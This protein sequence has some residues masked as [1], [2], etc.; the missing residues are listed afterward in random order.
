ARQLAHPRRG[1]LA[2]R[3]RPPAHRP[4]R[5]VR[6]LGRVQ[7]LS[8]DGGQQGPDG[9]RDRRARHP[10]HRRG[11]QGRHLDPGDRRPLQ[12]ADRRG[13]A[14]ARAVVRP[15]H[16]D[17]HDQPLLGGPGDLH[18]PARQ[19]VRL[20]ADHARRHLAVHR[21]DAAGPLHRGHLPDLRLRLRPRRPVRQLRQPARRHRPDRPAVADQRREAEVRRV[22]AVFPRPAGV[23][24]GAGD[25]PAV[26]GQLAPERAEVLPQPARRPQAA[27]DHPRPGLGRPGAAGGLAGPPGQEAVRLVRRGRRLPLGFDRVGAADRRPGRLAA[28]LA[29]RAGPRLLLHGQGQHRLPRRDLAG[30]AAGLLR[31]RRPRRHPGPARRPGPAVRG[32]LQRVPDDGGQAVLLVPGRGHRDPRPAVPVRRGRAALLPVGGRAGDAGHR[33][34]LGRVPPAQQRRAG[35]QLG[36]PGEPVDLAGGP[37]LPGRPG[38]RRPQRRRRHA[39]RGVE[40]GLRQ[41]RRAAGPVPPEGGD[42]RGHEDRRRCQP[43]HLRPGAVDAAEDRPGRGPGAD[44]DDPQRRAAGGGRLQDAAHAVPAGVV[45]HRA[46]AA[47]R[48]RRAGGVGADAGGGRGRRADRY[49]LP[50]VPGDHRRLHRRRPLGVHAAAGRPVAVRPDAA[51][52]QAGRVHRGRRAG[53]ARRRRM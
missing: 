46:P 24:R 20:P 49:R 11:R 39:A 32:R 17:H 34:H 10:D 37:Q 41:R 21:P 42:R 30:D 13:P 38:R 52:P 4:R 5:R 7:P 50:V 25:V 29:V 16:P 14:L 15:V 23:R 43:L 33:L 3:Q 44:G 12:P 53:P 6:A 45:G 9:L 36:Q 28:V 18:R 1:G 51:V 35:R 22:R 48:G 31:H 8:A 19:R 26:A 2:V 27:G 40:G 47:G